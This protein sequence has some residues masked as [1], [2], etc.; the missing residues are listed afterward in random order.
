[1]IRNA[2]RNRHLRQLEREQ[3]QRAE[4]AQIAPLRERWKPFT[5]PLQAELQVHLS[6]YGIRAAHHATALLERMLSEQEQERQRATSLLSLPPLLRLPL[7]RE[8]VAQRYRWSDFPLAVQD[9]LFTHYLTFTTRGLE[10][11]ERDVQQ[12]TSTLRILLADPRAELGAALAD[13]QAAFGVAS[14]FDLASIAATLH[15]LLETNEKP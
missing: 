13:H 7:T 8:Q 4:Q 2:L 6:I 5:L 11:A 3:Y 15:T 1:M 14:M 10:K 12:V 9:L